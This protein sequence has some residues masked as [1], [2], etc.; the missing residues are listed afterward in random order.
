[1][2]DNTRRDTASTDLPHPARHPYRARRYEHRPAVYPVPRP[3]RRGTAVRGQTWPD[4]RTAETLLDGGSTTAPTG[5][6]ADRLVRLLSAAREVGPVLDPAREA[7]ALAA[8]RSAVAGR[9]ATG[10]A[11]RPG[12][13]AALRAA[14]AVRRPRVMAAA[15]VSALAL[16][17]VVVGMAAAARS[18]APGGAGTSP[19]E[20]RP[21]AA[22]SPDGGRLGPWTA[23]PTTR[24]PAPRATGTPQREHDTGR[25]VR[26]CRGAPAPCRTDAGTGDGSRTG[27]HGRGTHRGSGQGNGQG[28]EQGN[29]NDQGNDRDGG[30]GYS[31]GDGWN[32]WGERVDAPQSPE[33]YGAPDHGQDPSAAYPAGGAGGAGGQATADRPDQGDRAG[34]PPGSAGSRTTRPGH[35]SPSRPPGR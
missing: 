28:N 12:R 32:S 2:S 22:V 9:A 29:D 6:P 16:G 10:E 27:G 7:A 25:T 24:F 34:R 30:G 15:V 23:G 4:A 26:G 31:R 17:G 33:T 11:P 35:R 5:V 19:L 20:T 21:P 18:L 8:F 3:E 13:L 1:M 14:F